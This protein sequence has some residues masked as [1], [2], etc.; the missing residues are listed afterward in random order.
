MLKNLF[1]IFKN[2]PKKIFLYDGIGALL[3]AF[4]LGVVLVYFQSYIGLPQ[5]ILYF[6]SVL[7][8]MIALF[9]FYT[10]YF[11]HRSLSPYLLS[12]LALNILYCCLTASLLFYFKKTIT[13]FGLAYFL[14]E[15]SIICVLVWFEKRI[16]TSKNKGYGE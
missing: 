11:V 15:I 6:L 7:A 9:S 5:Q 1:A 8:F 3:T 14:V 4:M 10:Y 13:A 2:N 16:L 12:I